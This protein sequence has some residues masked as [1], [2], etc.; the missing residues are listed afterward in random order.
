MRTHRLATLEDIPALV[1][2]AKAA[3]QEGLDLPDLCC[4]TEQD[5]QII[6]AVG[7]ELG[8]G[9]VVISGAVIHPDHYRNPFIVFR[10]QEFMEDWLIQRG[11]F[12]YVCSISKRNTRMQRWVE[13]LGAKRYTKKHG[14]FWYLRTIGPKRNALEESAA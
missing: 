13:K 4:V 6:A 8:D 7:I 12:A 11:C 9:M 14:A 1:D 2:L 3:K 5:G 10:L